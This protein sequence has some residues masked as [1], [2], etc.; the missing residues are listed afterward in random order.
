M[1]QLEDRLSKADRRAKA[2]MKERDMLRRSAESSDSAEVH[3][4][5]AT[6]LA[7]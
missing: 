1:T 2:I 4:T 3:T 5:M 6:I 7:V